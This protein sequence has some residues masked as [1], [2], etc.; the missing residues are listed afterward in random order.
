MKNI[1]L[2]Y[3]RYPDTFWGFRHALKFASKR[4]ALP[5][6]GLLTIA[7]YLPKSW[8]V[9][10]V[11]MNCERL[12]ENDIRNSDYVFISAMAVQRKSVN[13]VIRRCNE[14]NIPVVVGGPLFTTEPDHFPNANHFVLGEAEEIMPKLVEDIEN[15]KVKK[16]YSSQKFPDITKVRVPRWELLNLKW[17]YSMCVQ[18]SRGCPYDC[19]F[20]EIGALNGRIPRTKRTEQVIQEL[21]SLYD[22]GWRKAVFFV[23]DNFIGKKIDLKQEVLPAII[24]W[25]K[26]HGYPFTFYTEVSIDLSDD[27]ELM[28]LMTEAGFNRVFVGIETPDLDSLKEANKYQNIKHDLEK[29]VKR[30]HSFGLEV[31]GGFIIGFD[32]DTPSIFKHQF[33][34]IQKTGIVTAMVGMLNAPRGSKLYR[35][36]QDENRL[37]SEF[38]ENNVDISINFIP[39]M[40]IKTLISGYQNLMKQ[41]YSPANYYK[42]LRNFL[43]VYKFPKTLRLKKIT[44]TEI[45]AFLR[46]IVMIGILGKERFEYWKLLI[47]SLFKKRKHFPLVVTLAISGYHFRKIAEQ[48][49]KKKISPTIEKSF[50]SENFVIK[51]S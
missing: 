24:N 29:S 43:S 26:A 47:W 33:N 6:L 30:L 27:D 31:Q 35:R 2:I 16:Y 13:D 39:K 21:Q 40:N 4:A 44:F 1:L 12:R 7:S 18:Y 45:K 51:S 38:V 36:M 20:C 28:S 32:N 50:S 15:E 9:K 11:D 42:R 41:L 17:Y 46:S 14:L 10:L 49:S 19:E 22:F 3:P 8:N 5:P 23:D 37:I 34:F 25:Q 48:I